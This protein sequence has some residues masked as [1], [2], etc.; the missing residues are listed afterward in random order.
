MGA[1]GEG[2]L[3]CL[4]CAE[5]GTPPFR[6]PQHLPTIPGCVSCS[7]RLFTSCWLIY[8][9]LDPYY[10]LSRLPTIHFLDATSQEESAVPLRLR[11][12]FAFPGN[13]PTLHGMRMASTGASDLSQIR[14][15]LKASGAWNSM[16]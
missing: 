14:V 15:L 11:T 8:D 13:K 4:C 10:D 1:R 16:T 2:F 7:T 5:H 6:L 12:I 3:A 9:S